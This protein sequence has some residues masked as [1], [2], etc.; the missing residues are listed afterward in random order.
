MFHPLVVSRNN[1]KRK[2]IV[3]FWIFRKKGR[4]KPN[5]QKIKLLGGYMPIYYYF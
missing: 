4:N 3:S 5:M 1:Q 2:K